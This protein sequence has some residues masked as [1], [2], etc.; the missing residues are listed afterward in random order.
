MT[1]TDAAPVARAVAVAVILARSAPNMCM[2]VVRAWLSIATVTVFLRLSAE[3]ETSALRCDSANACRA[4]VLATLVIVA[5]LVLPSRNSRA[6]ARAALSAA[7]CSSV[8]A[9]ES[10]P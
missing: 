8:R 9:V 2:I 3:V 7:F 1:H 6:A 10:T 4:K 5:S